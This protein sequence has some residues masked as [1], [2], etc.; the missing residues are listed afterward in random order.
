MFLNT[1]LFIAVL[2]ALCAN[3]R[4]EGMIWMIPFKMIAG[5]I[6]Y[7]AGP[8]TV[9]GIENIP[10]SGGALLVFNHQSFVDCI[11]IQY[12]CPRFIHPMTR[13]ELFSN[14]TLGAKILTWMI[15]LFGGFS[16]KRCWLLKMEQGINITDFRGVLKAFRLLKAGKIVSIH[17]EGII[18]RNP[19]QL[20]EF[21]RGVAF[22]ARLTGVPVICGA[23]IN[24]GKVWPPAPHGDAQS[25]LPKQLRVGL[26]VIFDTP[27]LYS[28]LVPKVTSKKAIGDA[29]ATKAFQQAVEALSQSYA[30]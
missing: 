21:Q 1:Q 12:L 20:L 26:K 18:N 7:F 25:I 16:V 10:K 5:I 22:L 9:E 23:I 4:V 28:Q 3:R 15:Q 13:E 6:F 29:V 17:A 8:L 27:R 19:A 2:F 14:R 24:S 30:S 11:I